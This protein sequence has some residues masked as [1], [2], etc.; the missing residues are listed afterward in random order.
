MATET[1]A[2]ASARNETVEMISCPICLEDYTAIARK[3]ITCNYCRKNSCS[4]CV[5]RYLLHS[6]EDP[7]CLHCRQAW[8]RELLATYCTKT[9]LNQTYYKHRQD[10]LLSRERS[11]LPELQVH[12]E[13]E[14]RARVYIQEADKVQEQIRI[15]TED[16]NKKLQ[17]LN[18]LATNHRNNAWRVRNNRPVAGDNTEEATEGGG[19]AGG[20]A[21]ATATATAEATEER[22]K[23]IRRCTSEGCNGYLSTQWKCGLCQ[24]WVCPDCFEVKGLEKDT[25]HTCKPENIETARLI[26]KDTKP[27]PSCGEMIMK[28]DGCDQMWCISCHTP[29][30][31]ATGAIIR[32][33]IVHNPHYYQWL[34]KTGG[35]GGNVPRNG[36]DIPCGGLQ[37]IYR[38]RRALRN[39]P[40]VDLTDF[41]HM[42]RICAHIIDIERRNYE[43]HL[44]ADD[45][46]A[47]G[48]SYLLSELSEDEWKKTLAKKEKARQKSKEIRDILDAFNGAVIDISRRINTMTEYTRNDGIQLIEE[49][50]RELNALREFTMEAMLAVGR[51]F[52]CAVPYLDSKWVLSRINPINAARRKRQEQPE[53]E[54]NSDS[55]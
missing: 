38:I 49:I 2:T 4:K 34:A 28:Q 43:V 10:V 47:I 3:C 54:N 36:A 53:E 21:V 17:K 1:P 29:F 27:C 22:R 19:A 35:V 46:R 33:G 23:F 25:Q 32:T 16:V 48:I 41:T 13:R 40:S 6:L 5:E 7:H 39:I 30:S 42:Y 15:L 12:A 11:R 20:A 9:F 52:N 55:E 26:A 8:S 51:S 31:W 45:N 24:N 44:R 14:R 37:D 18:R 50:T